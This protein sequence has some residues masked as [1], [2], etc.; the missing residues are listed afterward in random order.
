MNFNELT[1]EQLVI[2]SRRCKQSLLYFTRFWFKVIHNSKFILNWHHEKIC[3]EL[4]KVANYKYEFLNINIPPRHSKT[5]LA[6]INFIAWS[7]ANNPKAN[8]LYITASDEL[9]SDTSI[10]IRDIITHPYFK[11][12]FGVEIKKD[13]SGKNLWKTNFGGGLKTATIF[14]QIT[15]FGA[16]RMYDKELINYI[17]EF[18]GC[19]T[20][21]DINKILDTENNTAN[22]DKAL[23]VLFNTILSRKNSEDTPIL[24]M[25]QRT[26]RNDA[27]GVLLDHFKDYKIL[28]LV[29]PVVN[30]GV[31]LWENKLN[32]KQIEKLRTS[33]ETKRIFQTQYMQNPQPR[34]SLLF[35]L[36]K[37]KFFKNY[38]R[39]NSFARVVY[40]DTADEGKDYLFAVFADLIKE[41]N[42]L[43]V[44]VDEI[45]YN[46]SRL[47]VNQP[48]IIEKVNNQKTDFFIIESNLLSSV[49]INNLKKQLQGAFLIPVKNFKNKEERIIKEADWILELFHFRDLPENTPYGLALKH[50]FNYQGY[51]KNQKDDCPDGLAGLNN[52]L[53]EKFKNH[54]IKL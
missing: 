39:E 21:D 29:I 32:L 23:K 48:K 19:I 33:P 1:D 43:S 47:I 14:G 38:H 24:N 18:D 7:L 35:P 45:I 2:A 52:F 13:Q 26:G 5:E 44:F 22:N 31:P 17:R 25:Q 46:Q 8:F 40:V 10:R 11:K 41:D 20:L 54:F 50:L 9:R 3:K 6:G 53:K 42:R 51:V 34:E 30:N 15:G 37:I 28:N 36:E 27:T 49:E 16:G 4:E 12:M